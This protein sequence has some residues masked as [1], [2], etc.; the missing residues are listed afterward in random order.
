[1]PL[2][3]LYTFVAR[4]EA[5]LVSS[6]QFVDPYDWKINLIFS[7]SSDLKQDICVDLCRQGIT[8]CISYTPAFAVSYTAQYTLWR[9]DVRVAYPI[10]SH[11]SLNNTS[12]FILVVDIGS[13]R[14][15]ECIYRQICIGNLKRRNYLQYLSVTERIKLNWSLRQGRIKLFGAPRQ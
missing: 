14:S 8:Y 15:L 1:M 2:L 12:T 3:T 4:T 9:R 13:L 10:R 11:D 5:S 6:Y 7:S